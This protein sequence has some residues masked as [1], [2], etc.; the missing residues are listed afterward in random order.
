MWRLTVILLLLVAGCS[1]VD[2]AAERASALAFHEA[3]LEAHRSGD[4]DWFADTVADS[5]RVS[6]DGAI[7]RPTR[8]EIRARF[9][10]YL[11]STTFSVYENLEPPVVRVSDDG[12][13]AWIL[14]RVRAEGVRRFGHSSEEDLTRM[15]AAWGACGTCCAEDLDGNLDVGFSDLTTLLAAWGPCP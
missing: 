15:L 9:Q 11:E 6:S 13:M 1:R 4:Y 14:V 5:F 7:T 2:P 10:Q 8:A 3:A 12:T